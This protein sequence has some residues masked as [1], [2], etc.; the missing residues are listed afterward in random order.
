MKVLKGK[1][2]VVNTFIEKDFEL[3]T[4][5]REGYVFDCWYYNGNKVI[6][7]KFLYTVVLLMTHSRLF[8]DI[9]KFTLNTVFKY[10]NTFS[11]EDQT[12]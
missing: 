7:G 6:S 4:P 10:S 8:W 2:I 11:K 3:I 1:F 5:I 9:A 12:L